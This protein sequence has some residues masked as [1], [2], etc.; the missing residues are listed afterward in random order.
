MSGMF[1]ASL[2]TRLFTSSKGCRYGSCTIA[3]KACSNGSSIRE[4][5]VRICSKHSSMS[6]GTSRG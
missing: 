4:A 2:D 5:L 6:C 1:A 3:K